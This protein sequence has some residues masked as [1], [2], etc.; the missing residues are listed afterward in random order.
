MRSSFVEQI[1]ERYVSHPALV[2]WHV[3][4]EIGCHVPRS[5]DD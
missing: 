3:N 4:N 5:F 1:A 2:A